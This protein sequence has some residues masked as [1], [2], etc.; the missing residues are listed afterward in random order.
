[1]T[2]LESLKL[3]SGPVATLFDDIS[4]LEK[5]ARSLD[6]LIVARM[7]ELNQSPKPVLYS[8]FELGPKSLKE[9]EGVKP[10][11]VQCVKQA[12]TISAV[13]FTVYDGLRTKTEQ[14]AHVKNGTSQTMDSK[15]LPQ[16]DGYGWAVDLVPWIGGIPKWDWT[17]CYAIAMA[18][19]TAATQLGC[20]KNIRWG[21]AWDR[22]LADYGGDVNE[23]LEATKDYAAR[24]PGKDFLDGPH[25]EWKA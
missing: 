17:G 4:N 19:D 5:T 2:E 24:H 20:A 12:I 22:T 18:M 11:L 13:D 16:S 3:L 9:L 23:Y 7:N 10:E 6:K 25:F 15:H 14:A 1:M 8:G 21:A